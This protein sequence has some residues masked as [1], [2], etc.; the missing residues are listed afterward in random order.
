MG[1]ADYYAPGDF[2]RICDRTGYKVKASRTQ[3]EWNN[4]IVRRESW[5]PRQP[6]DLIRS[7]PDRQHVPDPRSESTDTFLGDNDVQVS[8]L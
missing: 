7:R 3:K 6:Q 4:M 1:A 2:N 8:D 5:E